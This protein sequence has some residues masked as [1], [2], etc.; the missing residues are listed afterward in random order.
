M[1]SLPGWLLVVTDPDSTT[2]SSVR[3]VSLD[4]FRGFTMFWIV[5]GKSLLLALGALEAGAVVDTLKYQLMHSPW[6]GLRFYDL[7]W[8]SFMLMVGV[9][10]PFS[11]AKRSQSQTR[12]Q[13]LLSALQRAAVLF[14]LGSLRASLSSNVPTLVELSS[15]LQPIALA[16]LVASLLAGRSPR[17][18]AAAGALILAGYG[19]LLA[20]VPGPD[21]VAG[22]YA[23]DANLVFVV[24][25]AVLGRAHAEGWGTVLSAIPTVST[26]ILGLLIGG[27]LMSDHTAQRKAAIIGGVG[28]ACVALGWALSPLVPVIMKLWTV[29]YGLATAGWACLLFLAFYWVIDVHGWRKWSFPF[30]IVGMNAI[31]IYIG[32][33]IVP[34]TRIVGIFTKP[35]AAGLGAW[36]ALFSAAAV[37][38]VE[39][40]VLFWMYRRK[41]F[42]KA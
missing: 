27:L 29:S 39:W 33:S 28:L 16:Y 30:V 15:A 6:E 36:G 18:Q 31:A 38:L 10:I 19:L 13:M 11:F 26:T 3:L 25:N 14:L 8:P 41:L 24:D 32:V 17:A 23:K 22:S 1:P 35:I 2:A 42:I 34:F 40:L 9:S 4:A 5:G 12:G 20:F 7:I 37:L 21:V